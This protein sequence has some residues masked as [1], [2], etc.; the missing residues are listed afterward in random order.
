[1]SSFSKEV[2]GRF[3]CCLKDP[4]PRCYGYDQP[5]I[6]PWSSSCL[7][8]SVTKRGSKWVDDHDDRLKA[9]KTSYPQSP[10]TTITVIGRYQIST[11]SGFFYV[12]PTGALEPLDFFPQLRVVML[13]PTSVA[14]GKVAFGPCFDP[15]LKAFDTSL[16]HYDLI[17][18]LN[19]WT[20]DARYARLIWELL[21]AAKTGMRGIG[22]RH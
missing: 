4:G 8:R 15:I 10:C 19:M 6:H 21:I 7:E 18:E 17:N 2:N 13:F 16:P 11:F 14:S 20:T 12:F 1:M 9:F 3:S 5:G 22:H